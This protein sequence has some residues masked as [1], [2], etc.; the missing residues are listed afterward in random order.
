M[1]RGP[2][3]EPPPRKVHLQLELQFSLNDSSLKCNSS[4][5]KVVIVTEPED[6]RYATAPARHTPQSRPRPRGLA[7][8]SVLEA[9]AQLLVERAYSFSVEEVATL[10]GVHKTT[11]Y[12]RFTTKAAL[13][14]AALEQMSLTTIPVT[15]TSTS[16][17]LA[18]LAALAEA[19][20]TALSGPTGARVMR[21]A[22]AAATEDPDVQTIARRYFAG[23][24]DVAAQ[25]LGRAIASGELRAG[26]DPV[27]FWAAIVN[28][29]QVRALLGHPV[30][31]VTARELLALALD[32][33]RP[34]AALERRSI[35]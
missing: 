7:D 4:C 2:R 33:A 32:G 21:A 15:S 16:D 29:L 20:A 10:A 28:P 34:D 19:V 14:G 13:V 26:T 30:S 35:S 11:I 6:T 12:R 25:I 18:D 31:A 22:I 9:T 3:A 27:L 17:A 1:N 5:M 8:D 23:R 24:F